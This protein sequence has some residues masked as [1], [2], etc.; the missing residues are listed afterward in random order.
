[1]VFCVL[2]STGGVSYIA[3]TKISKTE[4]FD[5]AKLIYGSL[6]GVALIIRFNDGAIIDKD[7]EKF[8]IAVLKDSINRMYPRLH[9]QERRFL[10]GAAQV[11]A[12]NLKGKQK[13]EYNEIFGT[14]MLVDFLD[15]STQKNK[16]RGNE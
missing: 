10:V 12:S 3:R 11:F 15:F 6:L 4:S 9:E 5:S 14:D 7:K 2:S 16:E 13:D 8:I 1:M